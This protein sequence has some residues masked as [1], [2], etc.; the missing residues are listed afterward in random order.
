MNCAVCGF[1]TQ[2]TAKQ[3]H[4]TSQVNP[5]TLYSDYLILLTTLTNVERP[6]DN[7]NVHSCSG[8]IIQIHKAT[9]LTMKTIIVLKGITE[10]F[11]TEKIITIPKE[12]H[13]ACQEVLSR[14]VPLLLVYLPRH[15]WASEVKNFGDLL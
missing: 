11:M 14:V 2:P 3:H 13:L 7:V 10:G 5:F 15:L 12:T 1:G 4:S 9:K 6:T 8:F